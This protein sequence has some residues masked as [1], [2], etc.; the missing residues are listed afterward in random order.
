MKFEFFLS[1]QIVTFDLV[2]TV[3][4][5]QKMANSIN[6]E[7]KTILISGCCGFI[8]FHCTVHFLNLG[9]N[10]IGIDNISKDE[11]F[12]SKKIRLIKLNEFPRFEIHK[13]DIS[14]SKNLEQI[15]LRSDIDLILH[16]AAKTGV[17]S[18]EQ[19]FNEYFKTNVNGT[20]NIFDAVKNRNIPIIYASSSS[21]YGDTEASSFVETL[22]TTSPKSIYGL[23]KITC[24]NLAFYYQKKYDLNIIGLRFFTVY[25]DWPRKDMAIWKFIYAI[26]HDMPITLF[27]KG[28]FFRDFTHVSDIVSCIDLFSS[29]MS[30][31]N[32]KYQNEIFNIGNGSP[33]L[34]SDLVT[35]LENKMHKKATIIKE[36]GS[37]ED[38]LTTKSNN[39]KLF[40]HIGYK[41]V[42]GISKGLDMTLDWYYSEFKN[43]DFS[44]VDKN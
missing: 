36:V 10:V 40:N 34:I 3:K 6:Y 11:N 44:V 8:G 19:N 9:H 41:P 16:L 37:F 18:S 21:V 12:D 17:R 13:I 14:N 43:K 26:D 15:L 39:T 23:T 4:I 1:K 24:E 5:N 22:P 27:N 33:I 7:S 31:H 42:T 35:L 38:L 29:Q 2:N 32:I 20:R 28:N 25:G 30:S